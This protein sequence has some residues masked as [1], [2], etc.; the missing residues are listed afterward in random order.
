MASGA[1]EMDVRGLDEFREMSVLLARAIRFV[2]DEDV[3]AADI[4]E[5]AVRL[6][7]SNERRH[8]RFPMLRARP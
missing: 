6:R 2:P 3:L 8:H 1:I 7:T 4:E 5:F